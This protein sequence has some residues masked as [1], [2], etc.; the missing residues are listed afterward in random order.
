[1]N[2]KYSIL[3]L[4]V[5][6]AGVAAA[7]AAT[8]QAVPIFTFSC[9]GNLFNRI[10]PCPDGGEPAFLIQGS[11]GNFYGTTFVSSEQLSGQIGGTVYSLAPSGRF[12]LLHTF[13]PGT[14]HQYL[15]GNHPQQIIEGPDGSL[16]GTTYD[17][18]VRGFGVLYRIGKKS[19]FQVIHQFCSDAN[20]LDGFQS[21]GLVVASDGNIYGT[22][23]YGGTGDCYDSGCGTI[24]R[25]TPSTGK[26][27][28]VFNFGGNNGDFPSGLTVGPDRNLYGFAGGLFRYTPETRAFQTTPVHFPFFGNGLPSHSITN[29]VLGPDGKFYGLYSI[30]ALGGAGLYV[31]DIDGRNLH[32]FPEYNTTSSGGSPG[33]LL[34][35][36]DG[37]FWVADSSGSTG[38]GDLVSISRTAGTVLHT[39]TPFGFTGGIGEYPGALIQAK[40]GT[41][42]GNTAYYG[43][44]PEGHFGDGVVYR[45]N[46]GLPP[47]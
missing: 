35:T 8:D 34:L 37:N 42:W 43:N 20:C 16:Y 18:G 15:S 4:F 1:M 9:T 45:L 41:L 40:N 22:T 38:Y 12:T 30:Y 46:A 36:S 25:V 44:V 17:G 19:G 3:L 47:R 14:D 11:D 26:Y 27:D 31:M 32:L 7:N 24:F 23:V 29:L 33:G 6:V 2:G 5:L 39:L 21:G 10:G 28:V 13:L